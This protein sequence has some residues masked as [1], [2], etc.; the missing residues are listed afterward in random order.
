MVVLSEEW[1]TVALTSLLYFIKQLHSV[2]KS[3]CFALKASFL[4]KQVE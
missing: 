3:V 2:Y 4:F 1:F